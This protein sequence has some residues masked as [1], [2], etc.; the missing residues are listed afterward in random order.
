MNEDADTW[1]YEFWTGCLPIAVTSLLP[2]VF[3]PI[4]G[5]APSSKAARDYFQVSSP[6]YSLPTK[7]G[8]SIQYNSHSI[9]SFRLKDV[10]LLFFGSLVLARAIEMTRLH[11]RASLMILS[12]FGTNPK[13]YEYIFSFVCR[14]IRW[15]RMN[16]WSNIFIHSGSCS[17]QW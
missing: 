1:S 11:E 5:V 13:S 3:F 16:A 7:C 12:L 4:F 2:F 9:I 15:R 10:V 6:C 17:R 14:N 8:T